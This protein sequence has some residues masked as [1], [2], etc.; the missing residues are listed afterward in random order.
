MSVSLLG[1]SV[2]VVIWHSSKV[3]LTK[4]ENKRKELSHHYLFSES[5]RRIWDD[6]TPVSCHLSPV[7]HHLQAKTL[8][9]LGLLT[10]EM[11]IMPSFG[12]VM[13]KA[14]QN[15]LEEATLQMGYCNI[16]RKSWVLTIVQS[17]LHDLSPIIESIKWEQY[18]L[19][20]LWGELDVP[21]AG[22]EYGCCDYPHD[23]V[24]F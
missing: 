13:T 2:W 9:G 15:S 19:T 20:G 10:H 18:S 7:P 5:V 22:M 12:V 3:Y 24:L 6:L 1:M 8:N 23:R 17:L 16:M 11:V 21:S 4:T 14:K